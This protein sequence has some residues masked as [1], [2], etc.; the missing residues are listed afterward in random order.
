MRF[1]KYVVR[2]NPQVILGGLFGVKGGL[3]LFQAIQ[4]ALINPSRFGLSPNVFGWGWGI[5]AFF[6]G[7]HG[8]ARDIVPRIGI[9]WVPI[10]DAGD[11]VHD[12]V[13]GLFLVWAKP[14]PVIMAS[15]RVFQ[16]LG[17]RGIHAEDAVAFAAFF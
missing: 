15:H 12:H 11:L 4:Q 16:A 10:D 13:Q 14:F 9:V 6:R 17:Q 8:E 7:Q 2:I 5:G 3:N 1:T